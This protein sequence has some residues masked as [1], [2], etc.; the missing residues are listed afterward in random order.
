MIL[1]LIVE[2]GE[3]LTRKARCMHQRWSVYLPF[4]EVIDGCFVDWAKNIDS[5]LPLLQVREPQLT[6]GFLLDFVREEPVE[7]LKGELKSL[8]PE[9]C[10]KIDKKLNADLTGWEEKVYP[11]DPSQNPDELKK[12]KDNLVMRAE[13]QLKE[14]RDE[15]N[16]LEAFFSSELKEDNFKVLALRLRHR[17]CREVVNEAVREVSKA[18]NSWPGKFVKA[19]AGVMKDELKMQLLQDPKLT[20]LRDHIELDDP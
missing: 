7:E 11:I 16:E 5:W 4:H 20:D 13:K 15:L 18:H 8:V 19:R 2:E 9:L 12:E 10:G 6:N 14:L 3:V 1:A 17:D